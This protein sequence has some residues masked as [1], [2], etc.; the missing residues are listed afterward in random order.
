MCFYKSQWIKKKVVLG[1]G[2]ERRLH[3]QLQNVDR[4]DF[5]RDNE[6]TTKSTV[7]MKLSSFVVLRVVS[8]CDE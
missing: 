4:C 8:L 5:V 1:L 2:E 3:N 7:G 6:R